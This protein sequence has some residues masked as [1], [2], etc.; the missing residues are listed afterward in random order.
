RKRFL[1]EAKAAAAVQHEHIVTI[2]QV[3]QDRGIP[4]LAMQFLHGESLDERLRRERRLAISEVVRLG[5]EMAEGLPAAHQRGLI[6]RDIKP[7]SV[8]LEAPSERV[9]ILDF[10]LAR[11]FSGA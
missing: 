1:Q 9:K 11:K 5:R 8:W 6:H 3:G 4:Y 7:A 2:Y 10:G